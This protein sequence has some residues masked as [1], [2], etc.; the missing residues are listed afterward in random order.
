MKKGS[1]HTEEVRRKISLSQTGKHP[2]E[3]TRL[4]ISL[5]NK[6]RHHTEEAKRK[7]RQ[8]KHYKKRERHP[9]SLTTRKKLSDSL[10]RFFQTPAG[11]EV[12]KKISMTHKGIR[13]SEETRK[14][15]IASLKVSWQR[16]RMHV[17]KLK[18]PHTLCIEDLP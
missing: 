13:H 12:K 6:G 16:K 3:T 4:K 9:L 11:L 14:K 7:M 18:R 10:K 8:Y 5:A 15:M 17:H 1:H 2:S